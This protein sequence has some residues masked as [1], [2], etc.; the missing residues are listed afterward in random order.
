METKT[1]DAADPLSDDQFEFNRRIVTY[2]D[3]K[4]FEHENKGEYNKAQI[5]K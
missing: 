3:Y 2:L 5:Y 4:R 1:L